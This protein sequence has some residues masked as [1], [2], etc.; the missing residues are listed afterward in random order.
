MLQPSRRKYR[1]NRRAEHRPGNPRR[2][3]SFGE[4]GLKAIAAAASPSRQ[5]ESA[6][7]AMTPSPSSGVVASGSA[8]PG[9]AHLPKSAEVRMGNGKATGV[10]VAE[11]QPARC[12][13]KWK[14]WMRASRARRSARLLPGFPSHHVCDPSLWGVR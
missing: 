5:I 3:V 2:Q 11:I 4:F 9:Q 1:K 10:L 13:T 12:C 8:S 7:R 14:V 6:R